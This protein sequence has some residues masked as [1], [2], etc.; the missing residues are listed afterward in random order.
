MRNKDN[1]PTY[2][3]RALLCALIIIT[4]MFQLTQHG[5]PSVFGAK[6]LLLL[7]LVVVIS[8]FERGFAGML[9]G[10]F[11][12]TL[13]DIFSASHDGFYVIAFTVIGFTCGTL[14]TYLMRN[15]I[16]T[17]LLL[18]FLSCFGVISAYWLFFVLLTHT[19]MAGYLYLRYY[20]ISILYSTAFTPVYYLIVMKLSEKIK[21]EHS[22]FSF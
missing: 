19:D 13:C 20:L 6:A 15:N 11:A 9:F 7:P 8:M 16:V 2:I 4:S 10:L 14:I 3:R 21:T 12:G 18:S 1:M 22:T 17:A 5:F